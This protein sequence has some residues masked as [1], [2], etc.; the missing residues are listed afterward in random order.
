MKTGEKNFEE[1]FNLT[2][3][4]IFAVI[5]SIEV[6]YGTLSNNEPVK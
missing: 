5:K 4:G 2:I 1:N 3:C 6:I